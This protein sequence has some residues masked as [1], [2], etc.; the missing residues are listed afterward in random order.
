MALTDIPK[1]QVEP[2]VEAA[3]HI[4]ELVASVLGHADTALSSI[5]NLVRAHGRT[6]IAA[7]LG[8]DAAAMLSVFNHLKAA[9]EIGKDV[10]TD[11]LPQ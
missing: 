2:V 10:Q 9:V 7:E 6:A 4:R 11:D 3:V 1:V 5:R 8:E